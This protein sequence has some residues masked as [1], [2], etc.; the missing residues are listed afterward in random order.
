MLEVCQFVRCSNYL[1]LR[2]ANYFDVCATFMV[3]CPYNTS[4]VCDM[5]G[6]LFENLNFLIEPSS[7]SVF[8]VPSRSYF[9]VL[10]VIHHPNLTSDGLF[11]SNTINQCSNITVH[12]DLCM[13]S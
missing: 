1:C 9:E 5:Q 11:L 4:K 8:W 3:G 2:L 10:H 13:C 7:G 6:S 12:Y